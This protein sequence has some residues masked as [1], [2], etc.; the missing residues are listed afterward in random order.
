MVEPT[1]A[2]GLHDEQTTTGNFRDSM[3]L[4]GLADLV[5]TKGPAPS[6]PEVLFVL[7]ANETL[8]V[9]AP[10]YFVRLHEV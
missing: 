1:Q 8:E 9:D 5:R 2:V 10:H 3:Q 7:S 6:G 4:A